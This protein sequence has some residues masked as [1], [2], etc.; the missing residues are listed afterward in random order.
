MFLRRRLD[1]WTLQAM[2]QD[3]LNWAEQLAGYHGPLGMTVGIAFGAVGGPL[4]KFGRQWPRLA[5][6]AAVAAMILVVSDF[7]RQSTFHVV[8]WLGWRLR[9]QFVPWSITG[10]SD[11]ISIMTIIFGAVAGAAVAD[12]AMYATRSRRFFLEGQ[13]LALW[14]EKT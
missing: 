14:A 2:Q 7:G 3:A 8:T 9:Y 5:A 4:F 12:L 1:P 10:D 6:A 11:E 13:C